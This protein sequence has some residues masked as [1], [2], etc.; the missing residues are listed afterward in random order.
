MIKPYDRCES[1]CPFIV[2]GEC[3]YQ[4]NHTKTIA[5]DFDKVLFEHEKWEG[6]EHYGKPI[7]G[8]KYALEKLKKMGFKIMIWTTRAQDDIIAEALTK[9]GI[10]FDYIN[11]NPNQPPEINPSKPVADYYVDDRAVH[12]TGDWDS[13]LAE[14]EMREQEDQYYPNQPQNP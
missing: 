10:T 3:T 5:V 9:H 12:F 4:K 1:D 13:T 7:P 14:I 8:A 6:H 11:H 2:D